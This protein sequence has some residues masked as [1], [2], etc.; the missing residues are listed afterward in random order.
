M[1]KEQLFAVMEQ[2]AEER[3]AARPIVR[4][5]VASGASVDDIEIPEGWRTAGM[6]MELCEF[7]YN[8]LETE[9]TKCV[10]FSLLALAIGTG[11]ASANYPPPLSAYLRGRAWREVGVAHR[12]M[13]DYDAA[14]HAL[15]T[16]EA[17]FRQEPA[18]SDEEAATIYARAGVSFLAVDGEA[19]ALTEAAR[20][21]FAEI[22]DVRRQIHC[23]VIHAM[24]HWRRGD[25]DGARI[26]YESA[27]RQ[28]SELDDPYTIATICNGLGC[29][30]RYLGRTSDAVTS[31]ERAREIF[32]ALEMPIEVIRANWG[33][34]QVLLD[35]GHAHKAL[36]LLK[37]IREYFLSLQ[38]PEEAGEAGLHMVDA[39]VTIGQIESARK[40]ANEVLKEFVDAKL[41]VYAITALGYLRDL[42]EGNGNPRETVSRVRSY[43]AKLQLREAQLFLPLD[44]NG[45]ANEPARASPLRPSR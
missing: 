13:N 5:L 41:N 6:V 10:S 4:E 19:L 22:G 29:M 27:L 1:N 3:E 38:M 36:S 43:V 33:L 2:I 32:Q 16:A 42:L 9:P 24:V 14:K 34:A 21:T 12:Y 30:Y 23:D 15:L 7:A 20:Q 45:G 11:S 8:H 35:S 25:F 37:P 31:H 44:E 26:R 17:S 18:L 40:L 28:L 39:F